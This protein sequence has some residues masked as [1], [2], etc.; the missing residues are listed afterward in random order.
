MVTVTTVTTVITITY[1][2]TAR[3]LELLCTAKYYHN[4]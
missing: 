1:Q 3:L 4:F 2:Q